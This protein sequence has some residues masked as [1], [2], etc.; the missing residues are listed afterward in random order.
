MKL[1]ELYNINQS[2]LLYLS[3]STQHSLFS[4]GFGNP[5]VFHFQISI[6]ASLCNFSVRTWALPFSS[7]SSISKVLR[8]ISLLFCISEGK[9]IAQLP[10]IAEKYLEQEMFSCTITNF[11]SSQHETIQPK[12]HYTHTI[13]SILYVPS[14]ICD[15][16]LNVTFDLYSDAIHFLRLRSR[17]N[18]QSA[19]FKVKMGEICGKFIFFLKERGALL[20]TSNLLSLG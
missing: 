11:C 18:L 10:G 1:P 5:D 14:S 4:S 8:Q 16:F 13:P 9:C 17:S 12:S 20:T 2:I 3:F 6:Q 7:I 15:G 19:S